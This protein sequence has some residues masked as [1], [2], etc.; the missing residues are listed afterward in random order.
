[1][2]SRSGSRS[3]ARRWWSRCSHSPR[4]ITPSIRFRGWLESEPGASVTFALTLRDLVDADGGGEHQGLVDL[5]SDR[6]S[7]G[8]TDREPLPRDLCH[9]L[10]VVSDL[11]LMVRDVA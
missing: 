1:M 3:S 4:S 11:V 2:R 6:N 9:R 8:I 10:T 5:W 7:I